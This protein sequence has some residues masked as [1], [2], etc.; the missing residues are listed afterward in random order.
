MLEHTLEHAI[1]QGRCHIVTIFGPAGAGK[2]RLIREFLDRVSLRA[3]T[4]TGRC[5]SY[6]EG[7]TYW[8]I[9]EMLRQAAGIEE[10][11]TLEQART[12]LGAMLPDH[13]DVTERLGAAIGLI[14]ASFSA[15]ETFWAVRHVLEITARRPSVRR[16]RRRY[17]LG[18][19]DLARSA[20]LPGGRVPRAGACCCVL[21]VMSW[22]RS[23][24]HGQT[25][26]SERLR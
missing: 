2:S 23:I 9:G 18:G 5:L 16:A 26:G 19:A 21:L 10:S 22:S 3:T 25:R 6:G 1:E 15:E 24:R 8:P 13:L 14:D 7:I 20:P 17:P 11:D 12:K 4:L